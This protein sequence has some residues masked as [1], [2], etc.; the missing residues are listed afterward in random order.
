MVS[1]R[2]PSLRSASSHLFRSDP[3]ICAR[4]SRTPASLSDHLHADAHERV[5]VVGGPLGGAGELHRRHPARS[6]EVVHLVVALV[7][8]AGRVHPPVDVATPVH[9]GSSHVLTDRQGDRPARALELVGDLHAAGRR[10]HHQ[11][12]PLGQLVGVPVARRRERVHRRRHGVGERR[13][14]RDV[15]RP[16]RQHHGEAVPHALVGRDA[17]PAVGAAHRRHRRA[18]LHRGGD[19]VRVAGDEVDDLGHRHVAVGVVASIAVAGEPAQ[20]ARGEQPQRVPTL[21]AP[22][23][24]HLVPLEDHVVDRAVREAAAHREP[25]VAGSDDDRGGVH[26]SVVR[27]LTMT[28]TSVG[29]VM[30]S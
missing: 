20:P 7:E 8:H 23:A 4:P 6:H 17:V 30:T 27:Q 28:R 26:G 18:G 15:E 29:L 10:S 16:R 11:H 9:A 2:R 3:E 13:H 24:G 22:R 1:S 19:L 21:R 25:G 12:A 14:A 5:E